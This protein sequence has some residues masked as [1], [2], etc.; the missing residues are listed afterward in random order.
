MSKKDAPPDI[1]AG[2]AEEPEQ[3][4]KQFHVEVDLEELGIDPTDHSAEEKAIGQ[5]ET[6]N[7]IEA[8]DRPKRLTAP[9]NTP[10]LLQDPVVDVRDEIDKSFNGVFDIGKV[11]VTSEERERFV[12]CALHDEEMWFDVTLEGTNIPVRVAIPPENFTASV[13]TAIDHWHKAGVVNS[14]SNIQF[15]LAFQ[16]IHAWFQVRQINGRN[17]PWSDEF[18]DGLPKSSWIRQFTKDPNNFEDFFNMSAVRWRLIVESMRMAEF[19]YKLCL[20][21]WRDR[22]FFTQAGT[23]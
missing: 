23:A 14:E 5:N 20:E 2:I 7:E 12:R 18:A 16:Q 1:F 10:E 11:E 6:D 9:I 4:A 8:P 21:A 22:S 17:T 19:K 15:Y 3:G 13:A